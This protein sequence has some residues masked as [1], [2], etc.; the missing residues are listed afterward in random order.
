MCNS[1]VALL[2]RREDQKIAKISL[3]IYNA[4]VTVPYCTREQKSTRGRIETTKCQ[5]KFNIA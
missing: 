3:C 1:S 4:I 2:M 5:K